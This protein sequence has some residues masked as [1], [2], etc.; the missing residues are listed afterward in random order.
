[1]I[2][3]SGRIM[4]GLD[5]VSTLRSPTASMIVSTADGHHGRAEAPGSLS[6]VSLLP[7][8]VN[9]MCRSESRRSAEKGTGHT[10]VR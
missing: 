5:K 2:D 10:G 9:R 8:T 6:R 7:D 4:R 3:C 1:M